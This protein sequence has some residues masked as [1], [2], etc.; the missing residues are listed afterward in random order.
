MRSSCCSLVLL[1]VFLLNLSSVF[2]IGKKL[3]RDEFTGDVRLCHSWKGKG[4][5]ETEREWME[6]N[7]AKTCGFCTTYTK[8]CPQNYFPCLGGKP[9][10]VEVAKMCDCYED[11][12]NGHDERG[13]DGMANCEHLVVTVN[14]TDST[15]S[16][17]YNANTGP[18]TSSD[19]GTSADKD[20]QIDVERVTEVTEDPGEFGLFWAN[21]GI[22][23]PNEDELGCRANQECIKAYKWCD[24]LYEDCPDGE[25][26]G[27]HCYYEVNKNAFKNMYVNQDLTVKKFLNS[28]L[29]LR[30]THCTSRQFSCASEGQKACF[31]EVDLYS[32]KCACDAQC[33]ARQDCCHDVEEECGV[34]KPRGVI[35]E[36]GPKLFGHEEEMSGLVVSKCPKS[37]SVH[38]A[39]RCLDSGKP[40]E[41]MFYGAPV[42]DPG[43]DKHYLNYYCARC[44]GVDSEDL[45]PWNVWFD[46]QNTEVDFADNCD[47][48]LY[49]PPLNHPP[50]ICL[51]K[52][53][54][55]PSFDD[56]NV[57]V[58][59]RDNKVEERC[60]TVYA[61]ILYEGRKYRNPYCLYMHRAQLRD[62]NWRKI[63]TCD[64]EGAPEQCP[65]DSDELI[66]CRTSFSCLP[67]SLQCDGK[68]DC[69]DESDEHDKCGKLTVLFLFL[70][71]Y[72]SYLKWTL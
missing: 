15:I 66:P 19:N 2:C 5:C 25:D 51:A 29:K 36:C 28:L 22:R 6:A 54:T 13:C 72:A 50:N 44:N 38:D 40:K 3:C 21:N 47:S 37:A 39:E 17:D 69:A 57:T 9:D 1:L 63:Y 30:V 11:C 65:A 34:A 10:C 32:Y 52:V 45:T 4:R 64:F 71:R 60:K 12:E 18:T 24:G 33:W 68:V 70:K 46:C 42:Y 61:P 56:R 35:E 55:D 8:D 27:P 49:I 41:T 43:T 26:E 31:D 23:C 20:S 53:F 58:L 7:C 14:T 48:L 67:K 16:P 62:R 59:Q